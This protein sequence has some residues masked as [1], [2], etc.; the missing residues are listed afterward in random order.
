MLNS[1]RA[2]GGRGEES[3]ASGDAQSECGSQ[4]NFPREHPATSTGNSPEP[5]VRIFTSVYP[6]PEVR[7]YIQN[8]G[9]GYLHY[10]PRTCGQDIYCIYPEPEV[11]IFTVYSEPVVRIFTVYTQSLR[12]G[13]LLYTQNLGSEYLQQNCTV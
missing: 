9:S 11:R 2:G 5:G 4:R 12:S 8:L 1:L 7:M 3:M 6:E 13:Y 10:I